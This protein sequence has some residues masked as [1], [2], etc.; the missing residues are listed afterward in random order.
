MREEVEL[1][2]FSEWVK[3]SRSLMLRR[4][5]KL[6]C[7]N[8]RP[9][10]L[11]NDKKGNVLRQSSVCLIFITNVVYLKT[12]FASEKNLLLFV[13]KYNQRSSYFQ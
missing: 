6:K 7:M 10:A 12:R 2:I 1:D 8:A 4:I 13:Y 5:H 3:S 9:K 11:P